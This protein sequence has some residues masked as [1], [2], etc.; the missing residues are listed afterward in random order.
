MTHKQKIRARML[1][2]SDILI[3]LERRRKAV[4]MVKSLSK[5]KIEEDRR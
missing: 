4:D 1:Y 2:E 3:P 5:E